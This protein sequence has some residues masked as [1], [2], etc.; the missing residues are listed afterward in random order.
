[1]INNF[2]QEL[3]VDTSALYIYEPEKNRFSLFYQ[4]GLKNPKHL[5]FFERDY[6]I[7]EEIMEGEEVFLRG[8]NPFLLSAGLKSAF[9]LPIKAREEVLGAF[10]VGSGKE[11]L[12]D[13][14]FKTF[15]R[16]LVYLLGLYLKS[17][18]L[19]EELL[20]RY[21]KS[22]KDLYL[23]A[24]DL[25][26]QGV[27][28]VD[29]SR[30][31]IFVNKKE[32]DELDVDYSPG[33][34]CFTVFGKQKGPCKGC[35]LESAF[36]RMEPFTVYE[37]KEEELGRKLGKRT[38]VN[39]YFKPMDKDR[40]LVVVEDVTEFEKERER[41][42]SEERVKAI[43]E[44]A[45]ST[46]QR[47]NDP[48]LV[49]N[50]V[51]SKL[52]KYMGEN[53]DLQKLEC[54]LNKLE[55]FLKSLASLATPSSRQLESFSVK[56]VLLEVLEDL[57]KKFKD[58][59]PVEVKVEED[60][61]LFSHRDSVKTVVFNLLHNAMEAAKNNGKVNLKAKRL[62]KWVLIEV[63]DTGPGIPKSI[64]KRIFEPFFTTKKRALGLGLA[65]CKHLTEDLGGRIEFSS[66]G[67]GATFRVFLRS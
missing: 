37:T 14:K 39:L 56:E 18:E 2:T 13:E 15:L 42:K 25:V 21:K 16:G 29:R 23:T 7:F 22:D 61:Y 64:E 12:F 11:M 49:C 20:R 59:P 38:L 53:R 36:E 30:R 66:K 44:M 51:V 58:G 10:L 3:G 41:L 60:L 4:K 17:E 63:V 48:L 40:I 54:S 6:P 50:L 31:L 34:R 33:D 47:L 8:E 24:L 27:Y 57:K 55:S 67:R 32:K 5:R 62:S 9:F 43:G 46:L 65:V 1:M 19:R 28:I 52:K 45:A 26:P 35:L